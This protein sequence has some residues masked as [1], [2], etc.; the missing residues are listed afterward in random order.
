MTRQTRAAE[1]AAPVDA[2]SLRSGEASRTCIL[3]AA[4]VLFA[5]RGF[6]G[7]GI[8]AIVKRSGL[9]ASSL[10]WHFESKEGLLAAVVKRAAVIWL[11]SL[12]RASEMPGSPRE[13][14][15]AWL[16]RGLGAMAEESPDFMR[17]IVMVGL[18]RRAVDEE[19]RKTFEQVRAMAQEILESSIQ[20][21]FAD[22]G[23]ALASEIARS[24]APFG[25]MCADGCFIKNELDPD[26]PDL[27][28]V[29][30]QLEYAIM[31]LAERVCAREAGQ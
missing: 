13:R 31:C 17:L 2:Q 24:C 14:F 19:L 12:G 4:E 18:E 25:M 21:A 7:T 23:P 27:E 10:Y 28:A 11:D 8:A 26:P 15:G 5:E 3:D 16:R 1:A 20:D 22:H 30:D 6:A 29:A 9:P